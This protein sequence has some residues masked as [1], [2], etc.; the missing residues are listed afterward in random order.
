[1]PFKDR[2]DVALVVLYYGFTLAKDDPFFKTT[3][4]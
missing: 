2:E 4:T 3:K 1:M